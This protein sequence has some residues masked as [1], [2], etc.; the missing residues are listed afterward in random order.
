MQRHF[1]RTRHDH[2]VVVWNASEGASNCRK[3]YRHGVEV[4]YTHGG[5]AMQDIVRIEEE[6]KNNSA[7]V[8][9]TWFHEKYNVPFE[10]ADEIRRDPLSSKRA[11]LR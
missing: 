6:E 11:Q 7:H 3:I 9:K 1:L 10:T 5:V 4:T 2:P 8:W